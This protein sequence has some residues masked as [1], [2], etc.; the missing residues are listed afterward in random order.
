MSALGLLLL[1]FDTH[2][3]GLAKEISPSNQVDLSSLLPQVEPDK[4]PWSW[5][6]QIL[7]PIDEI[8]ARPQATVPVYGLYCWA[9][10]YIEHHKFIK[11][12]HWPFIRVAGPI[13]DEAMKLYCKDGVRVMATL[14]CRLHGAFKPEAPMSDWRNRANYN[15][16]QEFIDDYILG[17]LK[18]LKRWGPRG[19]FFTDHPDLPIN[20]INYIE[21][22]NEPNFWYLDTHKN[23]NKNHHPPAN[24]EARMAQNAKRQTLYAKLLI[25]S[26]QAIKKNWPEVQV[27]GFAAGGAA[28]ADVEFIRGVHNAD[29][30]VA[31]CY[32]ILSTHPYVRPAAPETNYI[33]SWGNI[34]IADGFNSIRK[35]MAEHNV[36][37][38][39]IW[40]TE[41]NWSILAQEGGI[42][43][44]EPK[45]LR[46]GVLDVNSMSQAAY[47]VR[48]YAWTMRL[49]VEH[50]AY[51]SIVDTDSTNS[52]FLNTKKEARPAVQ[53]LKT[54]TS[55]MPY[56]KLIGAIQENVDGIYI[57]N[58]KSNVRD[59]NS[60]TIIMAT[61]AI[62]P[63]SVKIPLPSSK[64]KIVDMMGKSI[65]VN[66]E[67][68]EVVLAIG[69]YPIYIVPCPQ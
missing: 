37:H 48:G 32:D 55:L 25:Q 18:I 67:E 40:Y 57:Y 39:P 63:K 45:N 11:A 31:K 53:A 28:G 26:Y 52:G 17:A 42:Y 61:S 27:V 58:F 54:M 13:N 35:I 23:D 44:P 41:L 21:I 24:D 10:E 43:Q 29:P 9:H 16:D 62:G 36:A 66:R 5:A 19:T 49:G 30:M 50:L 22:F 14:S 51:M 8:V 69:P 59:P 3:K 20:P 12:M 38:K 68:K 46:R 4:G 2:A 64:I 56:P 65:E 34:S 7:P 47:I 33:R 6:P 15:S 1:S 60:P